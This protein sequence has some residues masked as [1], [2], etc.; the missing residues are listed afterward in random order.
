VQR[1]STPVTRGDQESHRNALVGPGTMFPSE[2]FC[3]TW[4]PCL[5]AARRL[6]PVTCMTTSARLL[7]PRLFPA[8]LAVAEVKSFTHAADAA[9]MTQS[10]VSQ[11]VAKLEEQ[12]GR[13]L[14]RRLGKRV[15]LT[16]AGETLLS[17]VRAQFE[18]VNDLFDRIR[19]EQEAVSGVVSYA[20]P[21]SCLLSDHFTNILEKR[22]LTQDLQ[23]RII[24]GSSSEILELVGAEKVD[25]AF[26]AGKHEHAAVTFEPFCEE[27]CVLVSVDDHLPAGSDP[28]RIFETPVIGFPGSDVYYDMWLRHTLTSSRSEARQLNQVGYI[29]SIHGAILMVCS[30]MGA[31][32]L[33]RHCVQRE[34]ATGMLHE[35]SPK[36][37]ALLHSI[38]VARSAKFQSPRRVQVVLEWFAELIRESAKVSLSPELERREDTH[39]TLIRGRSSA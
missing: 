36:S 8:F 9:S 31:A 15:E 21:P 19:T 11:H 1:V 3:T 23:L 25:F 14:F 5:D 33:P 12:V 35:Y 24:T 28:D 7:D 4:R 22:R 13:P 17:Y 37:G 34:L 26:V 29:N 6:L 39:L 32:V 38:Y 20:M 2:H 10:G 18:Q 16:P 27:L 30:G